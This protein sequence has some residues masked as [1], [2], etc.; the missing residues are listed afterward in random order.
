MPHAFFPNIGIGLIVVDHISSRN[1][2]VRV[3]IVLEDTNISHVHGTIDDIYS[4][5]IPRVLRIGPDHW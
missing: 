1:V 4:I 2:T 5:L 3:I